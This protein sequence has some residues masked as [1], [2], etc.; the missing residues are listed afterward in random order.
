MCR[1]TSVLPTRSAPRICVHTTPPRRRESAFQPRPSSLRLPLRLTQCVL[2]RH[3]HRVHTKPTR[4]FS[5]RQHASSPRPKCRRPSA[6][7]PTSLKPRDACAILVSRR[8]ARLPHVLGNAQRTLSR[9]S[10]C[11][12]SH[13]A[14]SERAAHSYA[15]RPASPSKWKYLTHRTTYRATRAE[16]GRLYASLNWRVHVEKAK[17]CVA[18]PIWG[19]R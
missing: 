14:T 1:I 8:S 15:S 11:A 19:L 6:H 4:F 17:A 12:A 18:L 10:P 7:Y 5:P 16:D 13:R 9:T 2:P 3:P